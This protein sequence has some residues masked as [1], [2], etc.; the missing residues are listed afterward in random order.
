VSIL[1]LLFR[2]SC[3]IALL[4]LAAPA[5]AQFE[6]A[7]PAKAASGLKLDQALTKK[8]KIGVKVRA[9]GGPC[10]GIVATVPIPIDWPEQKVVPG[11]EDLSPGVH[12]MN[13]RT[14]GEGAKQMIVQI[15]QLP[16]GEEVHAYVTFEITRY[17]V[18]PPDDPSVYKEC[19]KDK[20]P[21]DLNQYLATSPF[22]ESTHP[23]I[24]AL[25]KE[26]T[27]DKSDWEKVEAIYDAT[28]EKVKYQNGPLKGALKGLLDGTGDCEEMTSLFVALCRASGIPARTVWVPDHC[29]PEF[30]LVDGDGKGYWFPCQAAGSRAFGGIPEH[31]PILQKGD[32]FHD[33]DRPEKRLR[34]VS[35]FLK[36][37]TTTKGGGKPQVEFVREWQ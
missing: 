26:V 28:R 14:L 31:R 15:P 11:E 29:Y 22:I 32:N 6:D 35:E 9:I 12:Q 3:L 17:S 34:Y 19:P 30:Y 10:K 5:W 24:V 2:T 8:I 13:Y 1:R 20:L 27:A 33:P 4:C 21:K 25:A 16:N 37:S 7:D 23:K 18:E 36:G